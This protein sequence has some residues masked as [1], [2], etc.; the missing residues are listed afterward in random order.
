[1]PEA[2]VGILDYGLGNI[3]SI[4]HALASMG[5]RSY[6]IITPENFNASFTN[7]V[8]LPGVGSFDRAMR[9]LR[10]KNLDFIT[11]NFPENIPIIGICL[12]MQMLFTGSDEGKGA[13]GLGLI[14]GRVVK[15]P[16]SSSGER[17]PSVGW[18]AIRFKNEPQAESP[19]F[20]FVHSYYARAISGSSLI[21]TYDFGSIEVPAIVRSKN[22]VGFQFHPERSAHQGIQLLKEAVLGGFSE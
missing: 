3:M 9:R 22:I 8:I 5:Y 10:E 6:R 20:Y 12:G 4:E 11:S 21:A 7:A 13:S 16:E 15:L 17:V 2:T 1:M 18:R 19:K 14:D